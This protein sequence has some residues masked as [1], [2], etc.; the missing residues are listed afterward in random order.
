[1]GRYEKPFILKITDG[2][3]EVDLVGGTDGITLKDW[4]P[5]SA[6]YKGGGS[7]QDSPLADGRRI[8]NKQFDNVVDIFDLVLSTNTP[9]GAIQGLNKLRMLLERAAEYWIDNW[10]NNVV[11][12]VCQYR[13]ETN[14]RYGS[15]VKGRIPND[16]YP[17][18]QK[19]QKG[20]MRN[21]RSVS[22]IKLV[23]EHN[24]WQSTIPGTGDDTA[25][26]AVEAFNGTNLGNVDSS[27]VRETSSADGEVFV[28]NHHKIANLT[29]VKRYLDSTATYTDLFDKAL[30][31]TLVTSNAN[32][33]VYFGC[34]TSVTD[35]GPFTS[36]IFD[37]SQVADWTGGSQLWQYWGGA[38]WATLTVV[39]NTLDGSQRFGKL[40]ING[41]FWV[42]PAAWTTTTIDGVTGYWV[43]L[44]ISS[45]TSSIADPIQQNRNVYSVSWSYT[46][47]QESEIGGVI[48]SLLRGRFEN[49]T[50]F[51]SGGETTSISPTRL[52]AG[53]RRY[54]RGDSFQAYLN[55]SDEQNPT[56]ITVSL[57][58]SGTFATSS[59]APTGRRVDF[60]PAGSS[61]TFEDA[62]E[63]E[64]DSTISPEFYGTYMA[65]VRIGY[66][67]TRRS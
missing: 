50:I 40:G 63:W 48:R 27:G 47:F 49:E 6:K 25:V 15:I 5:E 51:S 42:P 46:E 10:Q 14:T 64:F 18:G 37:L 12:L 7:M 38:A 44:F 26:S 19:F 43:R 3:D 35:S 67:Q 62:V 17:F 16:E 55:A 41:V 11:Y 24:I 23:T 39:D 21:R 22:E 4:K 58:A 52:Y 29:H 34:D 45:I 61:A 9:D 53:L 1:V 28:A 60:A 66:I 2:T 13:G 59:R 8:V 32:D 57:G 30:P 31:Y 65:F 56:G 54:D 36:L 20:G 33:A